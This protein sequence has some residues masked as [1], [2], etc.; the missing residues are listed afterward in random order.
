[1]ILISDS[2]STKTDW[3]LC[4]SSDKQHFVTSGINPFFV[5]KEEMI[6]I[7]QKE[8][9]LPVADVSEIAFYGAG[10]TP[11]KQ[12]LV[13]EALSQY[14]ETDKVEVHSDLL[15]AARALC[16]DEE[17]IACILGTGSN[18]CY[19]NGENIVEN[20]SPLGFILG[21]EG[22]GAVL[23]KKLLADVFKNQ[24]SRPLNIEFQY[25]YRISVA[26][27]INK[28][29]HQPFPN[30]FLAGFTPFIADNIHF[31]EM[32]SL[33]EDSFSEF[34]TRNLLQYSKTRE[35]PIHFTGSIAWH[36]RDNLENVL[37]KHQLQIGEIV[38]SPVD[39]LVEYHLK[40]S[41]KTEQND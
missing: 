10:C 39:G 38:K 16:Q 27:V 5:E 35:L 8:L 18:S 22:S 30:R 12:P 14:F 28:V 41:A 40:D 3:C 11:E 26:E 31:A 9:P 2:G 33:V 32:Q 23:G 4:D 1:M 7:L 15:G 24:L 21:D 37:R 13:K 19:Y 25:T 6:A 29:Y 34:I 20:I 17:G 36:F